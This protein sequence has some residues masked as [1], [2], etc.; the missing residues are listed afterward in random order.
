M[1]EGQTPQ[2][3]LWAEIER[4]YG[5]E[6][7]QELRRGYNQQQRNYS[8]HRQQVNAQWQAEWEER[9][10]TLQHERAEA[11]RPW[12]QLR[13]VPGE[14]DWAPILPSTVRSTFP[15][16]MLKQDGENWL[17]SLPPGRSLSEQDERHLK[18]LKEQ[19]I[20]KDWQVL[21]QEEQPEAAVLKDS[22]DLP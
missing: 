14:S 5:A 18:S 6:G 22:D 11:G 8:K 7:V 12:T 13:L 4:R 2:A 20:L 10:R 17:L 3:W 21:P 9:E 16:T 19:R 15:H 1:D